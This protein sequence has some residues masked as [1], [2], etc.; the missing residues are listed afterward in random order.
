VFYF[1]DQ[2]HTTLDISALSSDHEKPHVRSWGKL[3]EF[4][5][6]ISADVAVWIEVHPANSSHLQPVLEKLDSLLAILQQAPALNSMPRRFVWLATG[7][8][9]IREGSQEH[10]R[11]T[12]RGL[13]LKSRSLDLDSVF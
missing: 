2:T 12:G 1:D 4:T 10:R 13:L 11:L 9:W 3:T 7:R 8:V 6:H 5:S